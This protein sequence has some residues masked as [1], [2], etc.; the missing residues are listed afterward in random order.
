MAN[1]TALPC[2]MKTFFIRQ[3]SDITTK[4]RAHNTIIDIDI[5]SNKLCTFLKIN[6]LSSNQNV[7]NIMF[8]SL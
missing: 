5:T 8:K 4:K 1:V 2:E 7:N 3:K 6:T